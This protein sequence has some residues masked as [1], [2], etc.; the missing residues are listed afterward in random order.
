MVQESAKRDGT[1][2]L[3]WTVSGTEQNGTDASRREQRPEQC[4]TPGIFICRMQ[5]GVCEATS[6]MACKELSSVYGHGVHNKMEV[7]EI[8]PRFCSFST[9][10]H[11]RMPP[12][13]ATFTN[14]LPYL[15]RAQAHC[16]HTGHRKLRSWDH[17]WAQRSRHVQPQRKHVPTF[18]VSVRRLSPR[19]TQV[20]QPSESR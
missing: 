16:A 20:V 4:K 1:R 17:S 18:P 3:I 12:L 10:R 13:A 19:Q 6:I 2:P 14:V 8:S 5:C 7:P 9:A 15:L 11:G